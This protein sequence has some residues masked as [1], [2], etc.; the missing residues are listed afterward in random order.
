[1]GE[2]NACTAIAFC[3]AV[4]L[5]DCQTLGE[6]REVPW[7]E[8]VRGGG[9]LRWR[10]K[11]GEGTELCHV[12]EFLAEP[13]VRAGLAE[14]ASVEEF[15]G[16]TSQDLADAARCRLGVG[17]DADEAA[18]QLCAGPEDVWRRLGAGDGPATAVLTVGDDNVSVCVWR[19]G[20]QVALFDSHQMHLSSGSVGATLRTAY[21][22]G[23]SE[24]ALR[25]WVTD[26]RPATLRGLWGRVG[27]P[28]KRLV[29]GSLAD[30]V[31]REASRQDVLPFSVLL[32]RNKA[33]EPSPP[34]PRP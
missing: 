14:R 6:V 5:L 10:V 9:T 17:A 22:P 31:R 12:G 3:A 2:V 11:G 25:D 16:W 33:A 20:D 29:E 28:W 21:G 4:S 30:A 34:A 8:L 1:M 24:Q 26:G 32:L 19:C 27:D 18:W 13:A 23:T 7:D 15:V